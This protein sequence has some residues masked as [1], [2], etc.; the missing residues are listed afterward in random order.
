M[1]VTAGPTCSSRSML[2]ESSDA[3]YSRNVLDLGIQLV[4]RA[5]DPF[6]IVA[7]GM[8]AELLTDVTA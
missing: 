1:R 4:G 2:A 6:E 5:I 8:R 7:M 3:W